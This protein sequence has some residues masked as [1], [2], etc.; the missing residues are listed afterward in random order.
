MRVGFV[1]TVGFLVD[2]FRALMAAE[3]PGADC[4]HIL[5][6]S[7]LQDLL[8]GVD[9]AAVHSRVVQQVM[10]AAGA[11]AGLVVVT[12]SSTSPAVDVARQVCPVPVLKID[13]PMAAHAVSLGQRIAVLCTNTSTLG[14][15]TALLRQHAAQAGRTV[16]VTPFVR[17]DAYDALFSGDRDRHDAIVTQAAHEAAGWADVIVLAQASLAH[18]Q[19]ALAQST[20]RPV[21]CSPPL[22]MQEVGRWLALQ[23]ARQ[24]T[25]G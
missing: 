9:T 1:H 21:L 23:T 24:P 12:C 2:R 20:G 15:S 14:P 16:T 17:P 5:N 8:R 13:D 22:L 19:P 25:P 7:L 3:Q 11:G 4:F 18:L 6:E 10:L